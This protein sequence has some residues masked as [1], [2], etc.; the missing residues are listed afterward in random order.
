[1]FGGNNRKRKEKDFPKKRDILYFRNFYTNNMMHKNKKILYL[2]NKMK[3]EENG[4][5]L[6]GVNFSGRVLWILSELNFWKERKN[7]KS[8]KRI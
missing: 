4:L 1:M 6:S 3:V 2:N 7:K 5:F 8:F